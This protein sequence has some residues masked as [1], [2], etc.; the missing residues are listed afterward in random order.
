MEKK[1]ILVFIRTFHRWSGILLILT[2]SLKILS[3]YAINGFLS[4]FS[5][6]SGYKIHYARWI[7]IPLIFLFIF[8]A[9]YGILKIV[10]PKNNKKNQTVFLI[11]NCVAMVLFLTAMLF[12]YIL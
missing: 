1:S 7:D 6:S 2:V 12:I 10:I 9:S 11:T 4:F 8:H 3:G 5:Q